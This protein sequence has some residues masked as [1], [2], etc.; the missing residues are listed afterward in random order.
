MT[1]F[2][3]S[4]LYFRL[5]NSSRTEPLSLPSSFSLEIE[6]ENPT[7]S[8]TKPVGLVLPGLA[9]SWLLPDWLQ[10]QKDKKGSDSLNDVC[11]AQVQNLAHGVV[12]AVI[13]FCDLASEFSLLS[14]VSC[15][16]DI[17]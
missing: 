17:S 13:V 1:C 16:V 7:L 15:L 2:G 10:A 9:P 8:T 3:T 6:G 14:G 5:G 11:S 12:L 4:H